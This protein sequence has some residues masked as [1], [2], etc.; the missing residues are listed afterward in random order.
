M[1]CGEYLS[2]F[3]YNN[4]IMIVFCDDAYVTFRREPIFVDNIEDID[5]FHVMFNENGGIF[6][7]FLK[8]DVSKIIVNVIASNIFFLKVP[9]EEAMRSHPF[10]I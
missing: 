1:I 8:V 7:I 9:N 4:H 6:I 5:P 2:Y 3:I 10:S